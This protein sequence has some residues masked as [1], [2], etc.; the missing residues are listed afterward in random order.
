MKKLLKG[1]LSIALVATTLTIQAVK[2][3]D[4]DAFGKPF[5]AQRSQGANLARRLV[6]EVHELVP[7]LDC[8]NGVISIT[9]E[10]SQSFNSKKLGQ[11][12]SFRRTPT[13]MC[14]DDDNDI[15]LNVMRFKGRLV[16]D[17]ANP[18]NDR[19]VLADNFLLASDFD[20][21][22]TLKPRMENFIFDINFRLNLNKW[23]D[24]LYF[25]VDVP[26][27]WTRWDMNLEERRINAGTD[28]SIAAADAANGLFTTEAP[29]NSIIDAW[30]GVAEDQ[31][32]IFTATTGPEPVNLTIENM[33]YAKINGKH[34]KWGVAD[35]E[36]VLG[37]NYACNDC[38]HFGL[39]LRLTIPT[40]TRPDAEF[41]FEPIV[42]NGRHVQAGVGASGHT[43]LW[44]DDCYDR[45]FSIWFDSAIYHMFRAKQ[46][47]TFDLKDNG[48][49][50]RY[51]LFKQF[52]DDKMFTNTLV[53][54]PNITTLD[55]KVKVN[56]VGEAVILLNYQ[57]C[58]FTFDFGY[59]LWG[60]SKEDIELDEKIP[61]DRFGLWGGTPIES[62]GVEALA[63]QNR[64]NSKVKINGENA[65]A[66][67]DG[68]LLPAPATPVFLKTAN[69]DT[70][71]AEAPA[72]LSHKVFTHLGYTWEGCNYAPFFGVGGEV[73]FSGKRNH[74]V[75]QWGVWAKVGLAFS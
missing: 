31:N 25:E 43:T 8:M 59:N 24:G 35:V 1:I 75:D 52:N 18:E 64:T 26:V 42:G 65:S 30:K 57:D 6:G 32:F 70:E 44:E 58:G 40:G 51:L 38:Y 46:K 61:E 29:V 63:A 10:W 9:P 3:D 39:N 54:G 21:E 68:P 16:G 72:A 36:L 41:V 55:A 12:F 27:N 28:I 37:K 19:E 11:Y 45:S 2:E 56:A 66:I 50:S 33:K 53:R 4:F 48:A 34:K 22:V 20:G 60:R 13:G 23:A 7:D 5:F 47:R 73:E 62:N 49:G 71:S 74:A 15:D 14:D 69:I 67:G 17:T